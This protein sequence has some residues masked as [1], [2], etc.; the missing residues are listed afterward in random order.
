MFDLA[1]FQSPINCD[2]VSSINISKDD[3]ESLYKSEICSRL[4]GYEN[5]EL[6]PL[7]VIRNS[8]GKKSAINAGDINIDSP[9]AG[10]LRV[11]WRDEN[12][13]VVTLIYELSA[14]ALVPVLTRELEANT[15]IVESDVDLQ[16]I[17]IAPF[18]GIKKF[19]KGSPAGLMVLKR[20][21]KGN[22]VFSDSVSTVA[23]IHQNQKIIAVIGSNGLSVKAN[24]VA[25]ENAF[26]ANDVIKVRIL[27][28]GA[29]VSGRIEGD[30]YVH[31]D[32]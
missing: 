8:L 23:L 17:N 5:V 2:A 12:Q 28:T 19:F 3:K 6:K 31:V 26:N 16:K 27:D 14:M 18:F 13:G 24:A 4:E 22:Y 7:K 29:V 25:L 1:F 20:M 21:V 9:L 10:S 15:T 11:T 30:K 32:M